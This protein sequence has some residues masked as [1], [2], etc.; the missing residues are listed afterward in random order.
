MK[1]AIIG[2]RNV[3]LHSISDFVPEKIAGLMTEIITGG[4][5]GI[6]ILAL[7]YAREKN[8]KVTIFKPEY[9]RY[10]KG[11]PLIRN[12]LIVDAS[13]FV[14][15]IWDGKSRGTKY[16]IDYAKKMNKEIKIYMLE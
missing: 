15:A 1:V 2:S 12:Q 9:E 14:I 3:K 6:D 7:N 10:K 13:D 11:A 5:V 4:A 8:I 16:T